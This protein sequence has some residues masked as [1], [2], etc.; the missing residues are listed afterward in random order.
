MVGQGNAEPVEDEAAVRWKDPVPLIAIA[1]TFIGFWT[2]AMLRAERLDGSYDLGYFRQASWLITTGKPVFVTIRGLYLLGDHFSPIF[3]IQALPTALL[4]DIPALLAIQALLLAAGAIPLYLIARRHAGVGPLL[5][6]ILLVAYAAYPATNNVNLADFHPEV[7]AVPAL[8]LAVLAAME[9]RWALYSVS[10]GIVLGCREDLAITVIFLGV[11]LLIEQR[12]RAG[13]ITIAVGAV[14]L[15]AVTSVLI[16]HFTGGAFIQSEFLAQY[17]HGTLS[18]FFGMVRHPTQVFHDLT[19]AANGQFLLAVFAPL[20]FLPLAAPK[21]LIPAI[22][23]QFLYL[24]SL[25]PAAHTI[26]AQYTVQ[27]IAFVFV[28]TAMALGR[29]PRSAQRLPVLVVPLLAASIV[30]NS[31]LS[32]G[33]FTAKPWSWRHDDAIAGSIRRAA[34][35][36]PPRADVAASPR[37]WQVIAD[38]TDLYNF[39]APWIGYRTEARNDPVRIRVRKHDAHWILVDT[40]DAV[41]WTPDRV[42]A[43]TVITNRLHFCTV[44]S[45]NGVHLLRRTDTATTCPR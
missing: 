11:L 42:E 25:R 26:D 20:L 2:L 22:P 34:R 36:L 6:A 29:I 32:H 38:R 28:A 10:I 43:L 1:L 8:L 19:T 5:T 27:L 31:Q 15:V 14:W 40:A 21:W 33:G 4:P 24:V 18:A 23:L 7:A 13:L 12:R 30:A 39:P 17:G 41:Q 45:E 16:P 3:W 37:V 9:R 35:K 44:F